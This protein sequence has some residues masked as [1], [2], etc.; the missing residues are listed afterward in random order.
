MNEE[1]K[2]IESG[3]AAV[4]S[5]GKNV[6]ALLRDLALFTLGVLLL[7]FPGHFNSMLVNAGFEEGSLVGFKWKSKLVESNEALQKAQETISD[8]QGKNDEL[9][10]A[11]A[12]A[13]KQSSDVVLGKRIDKLQVDNRQLKSATQ[14]VQATVSE[15]IES[16]IPL[17][18]KA[19]AAGGGRAAGNLS[20]SDYSVGVQTLGVPDQERTAINDKLRAEGYGVDPTSLSYAAGER[21]SWFAPR[22]TVFYYAASAL[23]VAQEL[24]AFMKSITGQDY[25]VKRG[26]GLGVDPSRRDV[27]L[28]VHYLKS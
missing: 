1:S 23:P 14:Q 27:T 25:V 6:V 20:K 12:D 21:P 7:L 15:T 22:S 16:N 9:V 4:V 8:L 19:L 10:A 24:A 3:A 28:F 26:A 5:L 18:Q 11:L 13:K 2:T 17:V